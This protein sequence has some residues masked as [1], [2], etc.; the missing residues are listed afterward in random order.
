MKKLIDSLN[1]YPYM[2]RWTSETAGIHSVC[3]VG[4]GRDRVGKYSVNRPKAQ[5]SS[6]IVRKHQLQTTTSH[7]PE[8]SLGCNFTKKDGKQTGLL[9][10]SVFELWAGTQ[11]SSKSGLIACKMKCP[12]CGPILFLDLKQPYSHCKSDITYFFREFRDK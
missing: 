11:N 3:V 4:T 6:D 5:T 1:S 7:A 9:C 12:K 2:R 10:K 8:T